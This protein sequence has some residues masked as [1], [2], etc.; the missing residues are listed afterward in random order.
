M[1]TIIKDQHFYKKSV[2]Y[3]EIC[4]HLKYNTIH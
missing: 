3:T 2:T 1:E 4:K